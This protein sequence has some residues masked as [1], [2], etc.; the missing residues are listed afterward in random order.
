M[1]GKVIDENSRG[2]SVRRRYKDANDI[3]GLGA[4]KL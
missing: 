4:R 1:I 2:G 3:K